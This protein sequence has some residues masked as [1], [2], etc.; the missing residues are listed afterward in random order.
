MITAGEFDKADVR[1]G[2]ESAQ[3]VVLLQSQQPVQNGDKV[4]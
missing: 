2:T 1:V 4:F 3:S